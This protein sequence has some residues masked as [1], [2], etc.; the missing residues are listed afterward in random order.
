MLDAYLGIDPGQSGAWALVTED[1][2]LLAVGNL[3]IKKEWGAGLV[4]AVRAWSPRVHISR[5]IIERGGTRPENS[6]SRVYKTG[7]GAGLC[8]GVCLGFGIEIREVAPDAWKPGLG[9]RSSPSYSDRK[10][11]AREY[12]QGIWPEA[13]F[14]RPDHAEAALLSLWYIRRVLQI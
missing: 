5:A 10:R 14:S 7:E 12:A 3:H 1:E 2:L 8:K 4:R 13:R 9:L 6:R 11:I